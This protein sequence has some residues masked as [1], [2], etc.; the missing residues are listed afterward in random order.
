[1]DDPYLRTLLRLIGLLS[2]CAC[3]LLLLLASIPLWPRPVPPQITTATAL[4]LSMPLTAAARPADTSTP[5]PTSSPT[6][7]PVPTQTPLP[8]ETSTPTVTPLPTATTTP[9]PTF[10]P[11]RAPA[12]AAPLGVSQAALKTPFEELGFTFTDAAP[13]DG[14]PRIMGQSEIASIELIG[15]PENLTKANILFTA[16]QDNQINT[17]NT[18]FMYK[19]LT[20][21]NPTWNDATTWLGAAISQ[22]VQTGQANTTYQN[23]SVELTAVKEMGLFVLSVSGLPPSSPPAPIPALAPTSP[24]VRTA[25]QSADCICS[26]DTYNCDDSLARTCYDYCLSIGAGDIHNLDGDADGLFCE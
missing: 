11:T 25:P 24:A 12:P 16:S 26:A 7:A 3:G 8:T 22:A 23:T 13:V 6:T 15:P 21:V 1:M 9:Q 14:Q 2:L 4:A 20:T 10:T 19:L 17:A 18:Y 5:T